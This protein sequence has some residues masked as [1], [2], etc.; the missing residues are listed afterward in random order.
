MKRKF[1]GVYLTVMLIMFCTYVPFNLMSSF[2][3]KT[4]HTE[5]LTFVRP[6]GH[7][8]LWYNFSDKSGGSFTTST[9]YTNGYVAMID[10]QQLFI[11]IIIVTMVFV[12]VYLFLPK[13]LSNRNVNK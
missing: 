4:T 5:S 9:G 2:V 12:I 6:M 7:A 11:Q 3:N 1:I 13:K 10:Y 8:Q